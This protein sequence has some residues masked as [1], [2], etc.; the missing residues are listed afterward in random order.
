MPWSKDSIQ[1]Y[2][3]RYGKALGAGDL[4]TVVDCWEVPALVLSDQGARAVSTVEEIEQFF[5]AAIEWYHAQ[6]LVVTR[7]DDV[8]VEALG[9][10][11]VSVD[12]RW[13]ALDASGAEKGS[14][15]SRYVLSIAEDGLP[16]IRVAISMTV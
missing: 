5:G 3:E 12:V 1:Q 2:L 6:G 15:R 14:E 11:L 16:R 8:R 7:P 9:Q 10:Q 13:S 4:Q